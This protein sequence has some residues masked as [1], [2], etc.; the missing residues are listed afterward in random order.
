MAKA[1]GTTR[2]AGIGLAHRRLAII[3]LS[4]LGAQPMHSAS[5]RMVLSFNGEIYNYR[6]LRADLE[7]AGRQFRSHSDTEVLLEA[8]ECW[9]METALR[10]AR[11]MFAFALWDREERSLYLARDRFG[12]KPL[13]FGQCGNTLLFGSELKAL[14]AHSAW[15][16]RLNR[17][18]LAL[19]LRH[20]YIP[21]PHSIYEGIRKVPPGSFVRIQVRRESFAIEE[22]SYWS[23]RPIARASARTRRVS[24][25]ET[26]ERLHAEL[27]EAVNLQMVAD[28]PVGAF[29]SGGIDSSLIVSLMQ[30]ASRRPVRT[31]SIGFAEQEYNEAPFARR[32]ASHLGTEHTELMISAARRARGHS[33]ARRHL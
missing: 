19:M 20:Y 21:A 24:D 17:D 2:T 14:R 27:A 8:I 26:V 28:V 9:G 30:Q 1:F 3:D 7:R 22:K 12:E 6:A 5:G 13:H 10:R 15:N 32:I 25:A 31:F 33:Q 29:L 11:G 23:V 18:A 16:A 4:P